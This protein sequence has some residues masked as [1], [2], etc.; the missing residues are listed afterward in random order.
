MQMNE[1]QA[2]ARRTQNAKL[3]LK[4]RKEHALMGLISEVGEICACFQK[5]HQGHPLI[6]NDVIDELG[7]LMWF[8]AEF[9]DVMRVSMEEVAERNIEK[10]RARYPEG[11][12][13]AQSI[14]RNAASVVQHEWHGAHGPLRI[15]CYGDRDECAH[16]LDGNCG[17]YDRRCEGVHIDLLRE[18]G[19]E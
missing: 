16:F 2:L 19:E 14:H 10:L 11:F 5:I 9:C 13:E 18:D 17:L 1:Y 15:T 12:S 6:L 8:V 3:S 4:E 7:D